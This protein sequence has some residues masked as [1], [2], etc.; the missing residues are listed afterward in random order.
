[1]TLEPKKRRGAP[2]PTGR[3]DREHSGTLCTATRRDGQPCTNFARLGATVCRMHGGSA[4]Q[5]VRA[6]QVRLLMA[7]DRL[8]AQLLQI[9]ENKA[10]PTPVRL[11]A[12]RDALDRAGLGAK[13]QIE[14]S[15]E[16]TLETW[17]HKAEAAVIDWGDLKSLARPQATASP[18]VID[19]EV[20]EEDALERAWDRRLE[21]P[22]DA[23]TRQQPSA[24][25]RRVEAMPKQPPKVDDD[26][27]PP[28]VSPESGAQT[29][30]R[31]A[32]EHRKRAFAADRA[33]GGLKPRTTRPRR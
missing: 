31:L 26:Q 9:A 16:V 25:E 4:P 5:V 33:S 7:A 13:Q 17:E 10:E 18:D 1:M 22:H 11:A 29:L 2:P 24:V 20:V 14:L 8:M 6:A 32:D 27:T 12:I 15:A 28:W 21:A 19:A 30:D 3:E 23:P